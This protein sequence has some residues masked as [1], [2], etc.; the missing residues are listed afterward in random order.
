MQKSKLTARVQTVLGPVDPEALG[1]TLPHEHLLI[2]MEVWYQEPG[3]ASRRSLARQPVSLENLSWVRWNVYNNLDNL[4]LQNEQTAI[5]EALQFKYAG[6]GTIIDVTSCGLGRDPSGLARISRATGLN[7]VMGAGF[8]V[9]AAV[10]PDFDSKAE[11]ELAEI[12][13]KDIREGVDGTEIRAGVIG[14]VG[15]DWPLAD[16]EIKSLRAAAMAQQNTGAMIT[17]HPGRHEDSPMQILKILDKAGADLTRVVMSHLDRTGFLPETRVE[18][19]K[20]GCYLEYDGFGA[21]P[22]YPLRFGVFDRPSDVQRIRQIIDLIE[23]GYLSQILISHDVCMKIRLTCY[24][25]IGYAHILN[26]VLPQMRARGM[27]AS[28]I[29]TILVDN[30]KHFTVN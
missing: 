8:Y 6:G 25:G 17:I 4:V 2:S 10:D 15:C 16:R 23:R 20:T 12:I 13:A 28:E 19:A 11:E 1:I 26:N 7:I 30:P 14:E 9:G 22:F 18:M 29:H 3:E 5:N 27:S 24:G 21:E